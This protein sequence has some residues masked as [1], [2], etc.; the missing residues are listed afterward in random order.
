MGNL[1]LFLILVEILVLFLVLQLS[2]FIPSFLPPSLP[3]F[4]LSFLPY[5][6]HAYIGLWLKYWLRFFSEMRGDPWLSVHILKWDPKKL[7]EDYIFMGRA[8]QL[9]KWISLSIQKEPSCLVGDSQMSV[10]FFFFL[11]IFPKSV[12][13]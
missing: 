1:V 9:L 5:F 10:S 8:W 4:L 12:I 13:L 11:G 3:S 7:I 2:F 6:F